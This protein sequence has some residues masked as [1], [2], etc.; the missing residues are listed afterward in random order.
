MSRRR[1]RGLHA[2][3]VLASPLALLL[4]SVAVGSALAHHQGHLSDSSVSP[5]QVAAGGS[6][7][8]AVTYTDDKGAA[9]ATIVVAVDKV[10][11]SMTA[12]SDS[13]KKGVR[14]EASLTPSVGWH[15][16]S[17]VA[18][19]ADGNKETVW[20]GNIQ[21]KGAETPKP[22]A[23]PTPTARSS[24]SPKPVGT[25]TP[26]PTPV[27]GKGGGGDGKN[28]G[29]GGGSPKPTPADGGSATSAPGKSAAPVGP[30]GTPA[31]GATP[32][33]GGASSPGTGQTGGQPGAVPTMRP[34]AGRMIDTS[35]PTVGGQPADQSAGALAIRTDPG[36]IRLPLLD[37][38][39]SLP[40]LL[41]E[42]TPT[43]VTATTGG[44][45]WAAFV[46]FGKRRREGDASESDP[47]LATSSAAALDTGAAQCL[48]VVDESL[49]PRW[50]RPSLQQVRK[51]D[52]L[53]VV[54]EAPTSLSFARDGVRPIEAFERRQIRYRLVRLLDCPDEVRASEIGILDRGDEVQLLERYGVYWRVLCPDGRSGWVHRMTLSE[55]APEPG[56][57]AA[58]GP[59]EAAGMARP[60]NVEGLLEAYIRA[61]SDGP[62][63]AGPVTG[64]VSD[65]STGLDALAPAGT[66]E[67]APAVEP[68]VALA[69]DYLEKAGFAVQSPEPAVRRTVTPRPAAKP[70]TAPKT[71]PPKTPTGEPSAAAA[72]A[73]EPERVD[74]QY[75]GRKSGG[76]RKA[77][78]ASQP[79][80]KSRRPSR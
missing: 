13:F 9:P 42:L 23:V 78:T 74:V 51:T 3:W 57:G 79:G 7:A 59:I 34:G 80:T 22:S 41:R 24:P 40:T 15:V 31:P 58:G 32:A 72:P 54:A 25:S 43:I 48:R 75:S 20:A 12:A 52:P 69:R 39:P 76:S 19:D 5:R 66:V 30:G 4:L 64:R 44:A 60:E 46:I 56:F 61:R 36:P 70:R 73:A 38:H 49:L 55:A 10:T 35:G 67:S 68:S 37:R 77:S 26:A 53:R 65:D 62:Y 11:R 50:R 47:R 6:V 29:G 27:G 28:G 33:P 71:K 16:I 21:V 14:Y 63:S 1:H 17:F 18:T 2:S 8:V 45:A